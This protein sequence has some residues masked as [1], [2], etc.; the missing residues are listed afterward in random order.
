MGIR[1]VKTAV[2]IGSWHGPNLEAVEHLITVAEKLPEVF[3][4]ILGS[5]GTAFGGRSLPSNIVMAGVVEDDVKD[6]VLSMADVALNP[7]TS[8]SGTNLKM[9][10]Y[11][12]AGIPVISTAF[13]TRGLGCIPGRDF[14]AAEIPSFADTITR[15]FDL[16]QDDV[17]KIAAAA[18]RLAEEKFDWSVIA[19]TMHKLIGDRPR[20]IPT[21]H[22]QSP[23]GAGKM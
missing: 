9:L 15:F 10:E 18:R 23:P 20:L 22:P 11:F 3:F 13:G 14:L 2:F 6:M 7:M 5:S 1:G 4:L 16:P 17:E 21:T 8:G 19:Q 12:A